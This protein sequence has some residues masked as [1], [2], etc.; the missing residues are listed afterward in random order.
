MVHNKA[1]S[2]IDA[3]AQTEGGLHEPSFLDRLK[4][5]Q[6]DDYARVV[7]R[8]ALGAELTVTLASSFSSQVVLLRGLAAVRFVEPLLAQMRRIRSTSATAALVSLCQRVAIGTQGWLS[9]LRAFLS[10]PSNCFST[11]SDPIRMNRA[12]ANVLGLGNDD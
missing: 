6:D 11:S 9:Q 7:D 4:K 10:L 12:D 1:M 8:V 3:S 2:T 5:H